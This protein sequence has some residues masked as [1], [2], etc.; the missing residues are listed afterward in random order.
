MT[1]RTVPDMKELFKQAAE[2]AQQVPEGMQ[3][4]A[5]NRALDLLV[6]AGEKDTRTP[7]NAASGRKARRPIRTAS[8]EESEGESVDA[9]LA[10]IDSTQH[11]GVRT[12]SRALDQALMVLQIALNEHDV[13][14]LTPTEIARILNEKFRIGVSRQAVGMALKD[15]A[16]LVDRKAEGRGFRYRIMAPGEEHLAHL[17]KD[18]SDEGSEEGAQSARRTKKRQ[19]KKSKVIPGRRSAPDRTVAKVG[20]RA[21]RRQSKKTST[22]GKIGPKAAIM[23]LIDKGYLDEPRTGPEVQEHLDKQRGIQLGTDQVRMA[24]LRFVRDEV[25]RR[26]EREDGQ[27]EYSRSK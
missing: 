24:M 8:S 25:L 4:A 14:G 1:K 21:A 3:E 13:D 7:P 2:I 6:G 15:A 11:P 12:A 22:G 5:F 18:D 26:D 16:H 17:E 9:L 27:Y 19:R 20:E 23:Q 10:D